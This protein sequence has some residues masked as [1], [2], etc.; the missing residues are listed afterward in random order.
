M[1]KVLSIIFLGLYYKI[2]DII[3]KIKSVWPFS[4]CVIAGLVF[5]SYVNLGFADEA[6]YF[7]CFVML[8]VVS[9]VKR[10]ERV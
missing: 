10:Y 4:L 1:I 6:I 5:V 8:G 9:I 7:L 3:L 2:E